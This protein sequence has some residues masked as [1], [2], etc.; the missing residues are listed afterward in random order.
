MHLKTEIISLKCFIIIQCI[1]VILYNSILGLV[2]TINRMKE[3]WIKFCAKY[4]PR[5]QEF[6]APWNENLNSFQK[7]ILMYAIRPDQVLIIFV[8]YR[9]YFLKILM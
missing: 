5:C 3:Q 8:I 2:D 1:I 7:L 9:F 4:N 6:P